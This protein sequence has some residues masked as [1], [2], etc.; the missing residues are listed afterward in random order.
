[1][2][3]GGRELRLRI[4]SLSTMSYNGR[5]KT[6]A[7]WTQKC[8]DSGMDMVLFKPVNPI[9]LKELVFKLGYKPKK[10]E[11]KVI[12][13]ELNDSE[14]SVSESGDSDDE[15]ISG[16]DIKVRFSEYDKLSI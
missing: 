1:M 6:E 9:D 2:L 10:K 8:I 16:N 5:G 13:N 4:V 7:R 15:A 11:S 12:I 14:E 3:Y